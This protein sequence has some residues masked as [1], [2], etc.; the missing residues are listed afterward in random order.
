MAHQQIRSR[1][2]CK[3][4]E[5]WTRLTQ[6]SLIFVTEMDAQFIIIY[7][8]TIYYQ[9]TCLFCAQVF[10]GA[11][12]SC[13]LALVEGEVLRSVEEPRLWRLSLVLS[14][15]HCNHNIDRKIKLASDL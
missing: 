15:T 7:L 14:S 10:Q 8:F 9:Q 4:T 11:L 12:Q 1:G 3:N 5:G 6:F 2:S 13:Q